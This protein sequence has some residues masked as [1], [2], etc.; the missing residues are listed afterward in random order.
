MNRSVLA[1]KSTTSMAIVPSTL[2]LTSLCMSPALWPPIAWLPSGNREDEGESSNEANLCQRTGACNLYLFGWPA[3]HVV[4]VTVS[5]HA[6]ALPS[7]SR[8]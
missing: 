4:L 1:M 2:A 7:G 6:D 3:Y 8:R 5:I